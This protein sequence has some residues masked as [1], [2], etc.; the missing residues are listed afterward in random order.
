MTMLNHWLNNII[1]QW[2]NS[3]VSVKSDLAGVADLPV[4]FTDKKKKKSIYNDIAGACTLYNVCY[5]I[6]GLF[7]LKQIPF[8]MRQ[9]GETF[10]NKPFPPLS[11]FQS[12]LPQILSESSSG[13]KFTSEKR[14]NMAF[15]GELTERRGDSWI[16]RHE[17]EEQGA[18]S[19]AE[20]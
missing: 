5:F 18:F 10:K 13:E 11:P 8:D 19:R 6:T 16:N 12:T 7:N 2:V 1:Q 15:L 14:R 20:S 4:V 9:K 17:G 3:A